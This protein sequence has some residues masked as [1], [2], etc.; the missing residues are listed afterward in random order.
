EPLPERDL[1]DVRRIQ[2]GREAAGDQ[3]LLARASSLAWA[4]AAGHPPV[5]P[6]AETAAEAKRLQ[7]IAARYFKPGSWIV[8][9][10]GP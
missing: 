3:G 1:L 4:V 7:E 5:P 8:V 10:A 2:A 6:V 9:R